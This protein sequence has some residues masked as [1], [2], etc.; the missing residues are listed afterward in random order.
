M[1][2]ISIAAA[3]ALAAAAGL[4]PV[5]AQGDGENPAFNRL[6]EVINRRGLVLSAEPSLSERLSA[7][8]RIAIEP[9][10]GANANANPGGDL[11]DRQIVV[12]PGDGGNASEGGLPEPVIALPPGEL[13]AALP[14]PE[15]DRQQIVISPE[16]GG[17]GGP[18]PGS[19]QRP[20]D[21]QV[22]VTPEPGFEPDRLPRLDNRPAGPALAIERVPGAEEPGPDEF[23]PV[24]RPALVA[25]PPLFNEA[26]VAVQPGG[27]RLETWQVR[28]R[29]GQGGYRN[30]QLLD[31]DDNYIFVSAENVDRYA[32]N[33]VLA[34]DAYSGE[35]V[36]W[37]EVAGYAPDP[38]YE[39]P[40]REE[41]RYE[42]PEYEAPRFERYRPEPRYEQPRYREAPRYR[43]ERY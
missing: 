38:R 9:G 18:G 1:F 31:T 39:Q 29:L 37:R 23:A 34:V 24:G 15:I 5:F 20:P 21:V 13:P 16:P 2:R 4:Q 3:L 42:E 14:P 33:Y 27:N 10:A 25:A 22:V 32:G 7:A 40:R 41:P 6:D 11:G 12:E 35:V 43:N 19:I 26:P 17:P 36:A 8:P 28:D 30:I